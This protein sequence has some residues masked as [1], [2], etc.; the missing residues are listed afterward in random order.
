[1]K[2]KYPDEDMEDATYI[3]CGRAAGMEAMIVARGEILGDCCKCRA[4]IYYDQKA[5]TK[6]EKLCLPCAVEMWDAHMRDGR[7]H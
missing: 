6:P 3:I 1:M 4:P 2:I 5:P 7:E